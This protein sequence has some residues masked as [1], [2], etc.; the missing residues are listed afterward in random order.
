MLTH[1]KVKRTI[2]P[3]RAGTR[4]C[5]CREEVAMR[6]RH[7]RCISAAL[8]VFFFAANAY[9]QQ[10]A[11]HLSTLPRP[12]QANS[13]A[14][15]GPL[16]QVAKLTAS[17]DQGGELVGTSVA[18][19][20]D[21]VVVGYPYVYTG[22]GAGEALV[23]VKPTK[24]WANL[25]QTAVL[26]PS[27]GNSGDYF[28]IAVAIHGDVIVV[29]S[30]QDQFNPGGPGAAYVF[31]KP[32]D[33]WK[34]Q[35]T[36]TAK[37]VASDAMKGDGLGAA[38]SISGNTI[39]AGAPGSYPFSTSG[40]TYVFVE[41]ASGWKDA[42]ETAKLTASDGAIADELGYSVSLD[43]ESL[44]AGAPNNEG[45]GAA[46]I[47]V[48]PSG[49]WKDAPQTAKLTASDGAKQDNLGYSVSITGKTVAAGAPYASVRSNQDEGAAY[50]FVEPSGGWK[51]V[52]QTAK[53]TEADGEAGDLMG[54]SIVID[55]GIIAAG[56]AEYSRGPILKEGGPAFWQEGAVYLFTEP[57]GGWRTASSKTKLNG[58]DARYRAWL[59]SSLALR[60][61]VIVTG[62]PALS[63]FA[64][65]Q[66]AAYLFERP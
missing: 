16:V 17:S 19:G 49:G 52:T 24:G 44:V 60:G 2:F 12:A 31:V 58:S 39:V 5:E 47:F 20:G 56:A 21:T 38:V 37:L 6:E 46:Y 63:Y 23:F 29:G 14:A 61:N 59:G 25:T 15:R 36:E 48:E 18:I 32:A 3:R 65:W 43:G 54:S 50:V 66:G 45:K 22:K 13:P 53:L 62:A 64:P 35:L 33:G 8:L 9:S 28:G 42:T 57:T 4:A 10:I 27:D 7:L 11:Q 1:V 51:N 26:V 55:G 41:P 34:G 40:A 30:A